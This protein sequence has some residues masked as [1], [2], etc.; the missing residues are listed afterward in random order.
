MPLILGPGGSENWF[1][2][3]LHLLRS[4]NR[5]GNPKSGQNSKICISAYIK[6]TNPY[7]DRVLCPNSASASRKKT[8]RLLTAQI[9]VSDWQ[10]VS[11]VYFAKELVILIRIW[12]VPPGYITPEWV[13]A[14]R[15]SKQTFAECLGVCAPPLMTF[16]R[17]RTEFW[18]TFE[19]V[20]IGF[21]VTSSRKFPR[22]SQLW[23]HVSPS[24]RGVRSSD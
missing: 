3:C 16:Q 13:L 2:S 10:L 20:F 24:S 1:I 6:H 9:A 5:A 4:E 11:P 7:P 14:L 22:L 17:N 8:H 12:W 23:D 19:T 18:D 15:G 21:T